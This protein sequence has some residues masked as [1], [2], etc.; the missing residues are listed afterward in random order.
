ME[1]GLR[2]ELPGFIHPE[3]KLGE[4][5]KSSRNHRSPF[6]LKMTDIGGRYA[7]YWESI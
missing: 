6:R 7:Q 1:E 2:K 3:T 4:C 5:G